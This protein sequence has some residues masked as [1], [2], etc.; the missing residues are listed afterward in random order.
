MGKREFLLIGAFL[1]LGFVVYGLTA[2]ASRPEQRGFS[3]RRL[4]REIHADVGGGSRAAFQHKASSL[5]GPEVSRLRLGGYRGRLTQLGGDSDEVAGEYRGEVTGADDGLA[6]A[7]AN[8][9][10][11]SFKRNGDVLEAVVS[12]GDDRHGERQLV[13]RLPRRMAV[14]LEASGGPIE[15][16]NVAGVRMTIVRADL[17]LQDVGGEVTGEQRSGELEVHGAGD[18]RLMLRNVDARIDRIAGQ[19][20]IDSLDGDLQ[21]TAIDGGSRITARRT[22]VQVNEPGGAIEVSGTDGSVRI[23]DLDVPARVDGRRVDVT[24]IMKAP[25]PVDVT[26]TDDSIELTMPGEGG[27][28]IDAVATDGRVE[29]TDE[30]IELTGDEREHRAR[31]ML[32]GGGPAITLRA[33]R[34]S[35]SL[36]K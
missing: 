1:A 19:V 21:L 35:I 17:V 8:E 11:V 26:T 30:S 36:K 32:D 23:E 31:A 10:Q 22:D 25:T 7:R 18:I 27:V 28:T 5:A 20:S 13:L 4:L 15:I 9:A 14:E 3:V 33:S 34:G 6:K 12:A 16:R 29:S 24:I 2:P